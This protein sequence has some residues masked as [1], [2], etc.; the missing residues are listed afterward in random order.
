[1]G[2]RLPYG[3][4]PTGFAGLAIN[5]DDLETHLALWVDVVVGARGLLWHPELVAKGFGGGH[6]NLVVPNDW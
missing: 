4:L 3:R 6:L 1:M 2:L 5:G